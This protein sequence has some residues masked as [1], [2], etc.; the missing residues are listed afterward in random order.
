MIPTLFHNNIDYKIKILSLILIVTLLCVGLLAVGITHFSTNY[1]SQ[2]ES[3]EMFSEQRIANSVRSVEIFGNIMQDI[4]TEVIRD[5]GETQF[6]Y[7][8]NFAGIFI[9]EKGILNIAVVAG[10]LQSHAIRP[11]GQVIYRQ[12]TYSYNHLLTI[13]DAVFPL[14]YEFDIFIIAIDEVNNRV[15]VY[16]SDYDY[17]LPIIAHL[18]NRSLF[19]DTSLYFIVDPDGRAGLTSRAVHG[20][21]GISMGTIGTQAICNLTGQIGILTNEHVLSREFRDRAFFDGVHLGDVLRGEIRGNIDASFTPFAN[22]E[23]WV[24]SP[25]SRH[26][27]ENF[28]NIRLGNESQIVTGAQLFRIGQRTGRTFSEITT[29]NASMSAYWEGARRTVS[30]SFRFSTN[31]NDWTEIQGDSGGPVY[32]RGPNNTLYLIPYWLDFCS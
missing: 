30:N 26:G 8:D 32:I 12:F 11:C 4:R 21:D 29:R 3:T 17:K 7:D 23:G 28:T 25:H 1:A 15:S 19:S 31:L 14:M 18:H 6:L 13:K 5:N 2:V 27:G 10:G 24:H 20:G 16:I 22:Q 9:D